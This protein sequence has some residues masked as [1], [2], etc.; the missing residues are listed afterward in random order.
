MLAVIVESTFDV[1]ITVNVP[2]DSGSVNVRTPVSALSIG[3]AVPVTS[4]AQP[5]SCGID[6]VTSV[7]AD[8][9]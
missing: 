5:P 7:L 4:G 8:A 3:A 9:G 1:A 6:Q 2:T